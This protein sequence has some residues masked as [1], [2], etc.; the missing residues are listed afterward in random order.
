[1]SQSSERSAEFYRGGLAEARHLAEE[2]DVVF[3][4]DQPHVTRVAL[5]ERAD[6]LKDLIAAAE[7]RE[8]GEKDG[9][10]DWPPPPN[11]SEV[12]AWREDSGVFP[13]QVCVVYEGDGDRDWFTYGGRESLFGYLPTKWKPYPTAPGE[14][15]QPTAAEVIEAAE[16]ALEAFARGGVIDCL[17]REDYSVMK[18]RI[19]DWHGPS[20]FLTA[21]DAIALIARW[22]EANGGKA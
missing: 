16:K 7:A 14:A 8:A 3:R 6:E 15:T 2:C 21:V 13:A 20:D 9:W 17:S 12:I 19:V 10:F 22:K 18:E 11:I 1:M 5:Y 4:G